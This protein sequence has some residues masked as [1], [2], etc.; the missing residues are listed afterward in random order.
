MRKAAA[1]A[2]ALSLFPP[3]PTDDDSIPSHRSPS[4][5]IF[6]RLAF[7]LPHL[8]YLYILHGAHFAK[9]ARGKI[10]RQETN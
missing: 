3:A 10:K 1:A 7:S 9:T 4:F 8:S 2:A 5:S 6:R